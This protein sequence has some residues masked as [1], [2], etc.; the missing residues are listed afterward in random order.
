MRSK[1]SAILAMVFATYWVCS[2]LGPIALSFAATEPLDVQG[3]QIIKAISKTPFFLKAINLNDNMEF[4]YA[5][6]GNG[7]FDSIMKWTH[8]KEDFARIKRMQFNAVRLNLSSEHFR[9]IGRIKNLV[10]WSRGR[11]LYAIVAYF[12]PPGVEMAGGNYSD[13]KF[14]ESVRTGGA[15]YREFLDHWRSAFIQLK[16]YDNV[17]FELLNEPQI[18]PAE[19]ALYIKVIKDVIGILK[20]VGGN[21]L[22]VVG[23]LNYSG[24]DSRNYSFI[25]GLR[26][27]YK[28]LV[29]TFHYY[30]PDFAFHGC[31][32]N[33]PPANFYRDKKGT[34]DAQS[35]GLRKVSFTFKTSDFSDPLVTNP[36]LS[37]SSWNQIGA[38]RIKSAS[39]TDA[40]GNI[41]IY[42]NFINKEYKKIYYNDPPGYTEVFFDKIDPRKSWTLIHKGRFESN[43]Q[44]RITL[45]TNQQAVINN[46]LAFRKPEEV[47][48]ANIQWLAYIKETDWGNYPSPINLVPGVTYTFTIEL[49]GKLIDDGGGL[50][51]IFFVKTKDDEGKDIHKAI[52]KHGIRTLCWDSAA[53]TEEYLCSDAERVSSAFNIMKQVSQREKIP[54]FLGESGVP[55]RVEEDEAF[56]YFR[57]V[58]AGAKQFSGL[59]LYAYREP[60]SNTQCKTCC[61]YITFSLFSGWKVAVKGMTDLSGTL[62]ASEHFYRPRFINLISRTLGSM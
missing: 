60:F 16:D 41:L 25:P 43:P 1:N 28:N 7:G 59:G 42:E 29:V 5:P 17:I 58:A 62:C 13:A 30:M 32:W 21:Q 2:H 18:T 55:V 26:N 36:Y 49:D 50:D 8:T 20:S 52:F 51:I 24:V 4:P 37:I 48:W 22:F 9:R 19:N 27:L 11:D 46:T 10:D 14:W 33:I 44:S 45:N 53:C 31:N 23:G 61:E 56:E 47:G 12:T 6:W 39:I 3:D 34:F 38:Y 57:K 15:F 54:V 35:P 40:G